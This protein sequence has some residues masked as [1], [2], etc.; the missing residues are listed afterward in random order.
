MMFRAVLT[1]KGLLA[2]TILLLVCGGVLQASTYYFPHVAN[3][4]TGDSTYFTRFL[5]SNGNVAGNQVTLNFYLES[6]SGWNIPVTSPDRQDIGGTANQFQFELDAFETV[7]INTVGAG[8]QL[9]VGWASL[10]SQ[11]SVVISSGFTL[12][13]AGPTILTDVG[14][15]P[16]QA[17]TGFDMSVAAGEQEW[18]TGVNTNVGIA[19]CNPS[20]ATAQITLTLRGAGGQSTQTVTLGAGGHTSRFLSE[21]FPT[22]LFDDS[23]HALLRITS[24]WP[25]APVALRVSNGLLSSIPF[26]RMA[27]R[28]AQQVQDWEPGIPVTINSLPA[29]ITGTTDVPSGLDTDTF[30]FGAGAGQ[31]ITIT[32]IARSMGSEADLD[33]ELQNGSSQVLVTR[34]HDSGV[35]PESITYP[36]TVN[37]NYFLVVRSA[38]TPTPG[39]STYRIFVDVH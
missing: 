16:S 27:D 9:T 15:L 6:G 34:T 23:V 29:V 22:I 14:I 24:D 19:F 3:G 35:D 37:G 26:T 7:V 28:S 39:L 11:S 8:N 4:M 2:L 30:I 13:Q 12:Y 5:I 31:T 1:K 33:I 21:L 25:I 17:D 36:V 18:A 20:N 38:H 32:A 10:R